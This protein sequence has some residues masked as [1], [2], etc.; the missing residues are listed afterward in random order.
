[1]TASSGA[2]QRGIGELPPHE[3]ELRLVQ[4]ELRLG[5]GHVLLARAGDGKLQGFLV[6]GELGRGDVERGLGVIDILLASRPHHF[7]LIAQPDRGQVLEAIVAQTRVG[8]VRLGRLDVRFRLANFLRPAA[9]VHALDHRA[10]RG[11]LRLGLGDLRLQPAFVEIRQF[12]AVLDALALL[13]LDRGD[14]FAIVEREQHLA[15][16]DVAVEDQLLRTAFALRVPPPAARRSR[17]DQQQQPDQ[18]HA[19]HGF[20]SRPILFIG[21]ASS[22]ISM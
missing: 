14:A 8:K 18:Q 3:R 4:P 10:L 9:V 6:D 19:S 16:I 12:I 1:M 11:H 22:P 20:P 15:E 21:G 7:G 2:V 17:G 13:H 5:L